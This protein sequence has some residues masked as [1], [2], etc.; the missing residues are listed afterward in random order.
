LQHKTLLLFGRKV[1]AV[2]SRGKTNDHESALFLVWVVFTLAL[3]GVEVKP[4]L[5]VP[6][7][8]QNRA[9]SSRFFRENP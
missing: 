6:S 2:I 3:L 4:P 1:K 8:A 5:Q 7:F 9:A